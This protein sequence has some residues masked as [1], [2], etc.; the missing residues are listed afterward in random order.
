MYFYLPS[1]LSLCNH[2]LAM[3]GDDIKRIRK[4][5]GLTQHEFAARL[6]VSFGAVNRWERGH[7]EPQPD[8]LMRIREMH[9]G[10]LAHI[11]STETVTR[12]AEK[13]PPL[14]FEGDPEAIKLV[15]D[16]FRLR[17]GHLFN[18]AYGLELSRVVPL[19]HQ[20]IAVYEH[21]IPQS[22]LRFLVADDAGSGK[23]IMAG[24]YT[25]EML[26]RGRLKRVL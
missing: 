5:M 15:V 14:D 1:G 10:Y 11:N 3:T 4:S 13:T 22:P 24:L 6:G 2:F 17:N 19:P 9:A 26:N 8:R 18:K 23:T 20:R 16:A 21:L 7:N 25:L 12:G